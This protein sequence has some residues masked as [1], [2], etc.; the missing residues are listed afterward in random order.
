MPWEPK[1]WVCMPETPNRA[2]IN[3]AGDPSQKIYKTL[4]GTRCYF[5]FGFQR[6]LVQ[7]WIIVVPGILRNRLR[8]A[9]ARAL[10]MISRNDLECRRTARNVIY[11]VSKGVEFPL[12]SQYKQEGMTTEVRSER[13]RNDFTEDHQD[14][15]TSC[16]R[17]F[18]RTWV[19]LKVLGCWDS[20]TDLV[21]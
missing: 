4:S 6:L 5:G 8:R 18:S 11:F 2:L 14:D 12:L 3:E 10:E 16:L 15:L 20:Q 9:T 19:F 13:F 21:E 17:Y 1:E 7:D